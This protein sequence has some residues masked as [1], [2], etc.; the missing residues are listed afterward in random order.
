MRETGSV[1]YLLQAWDQIDY[2]LQA[3]VMQMDHHSINLSH[4]SETQT[5]W[6]SSRCVVEGYWELPTTQD[7]PGAVAG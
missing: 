7:H 1:K 6:P 4:I 2:L 3:F 5:H